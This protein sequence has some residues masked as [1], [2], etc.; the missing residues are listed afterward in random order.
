M[1]PPKSKTKPT[2]TS[3]PPPAFAETFASL[4]AMLQRHSK[5]LLTTADTANDFQVSSPEYTDRTGRPLFVAAVQIKKSYVSYHL[6]PV[7]ANPKLLAGLSPALKKRMQGKACFNYTSI[8]ATQ[9]N[10]L[11]ALTKTAIDGFK[12]LD[13]PWAKKPTAKKASPQKASPRKTSTAEK[14]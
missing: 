12:N 4:R 2:S 10:E 9:L 3:T 11:S 8:D 5:R 13:L 6:L 7:Y 14:R 1:P